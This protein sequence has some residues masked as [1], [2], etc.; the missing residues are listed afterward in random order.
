MA[1]YINTRTKAVVET[2]YVINGSDW[3]LLEKTDEPEK[4]KTKKKKSE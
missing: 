4:T 2:A 1:K 3:E